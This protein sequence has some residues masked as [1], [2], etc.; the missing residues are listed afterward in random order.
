MEGE[1]GDCA[2]CLEKLNEYSNVRLDCNHIFHQK[3]IFRSVSL[4][5]ACPLCNRVLYVSG[6]PVEPTQSNFWHCFWIWLK[7]FAAIAA[8]I[9][10]GLMFGNVI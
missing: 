10:T 8:V 6:E 1:I 9:L 4:R 5:N 7:I 3:C 2:I